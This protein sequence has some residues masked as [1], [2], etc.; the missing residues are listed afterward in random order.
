MYFSEAVNPL[1]RTREIK[2]GATLSVCVKDG[3]GNVTFRHGTEGT[4]G[5][6]SGIFVHDQTLTLYKFLEKDYCEVW[7]KVCMCVSVWV[8]SSNKKLIFT[9]R[10]LNVQNVIFPS[11]VKFDAKF[12]PS[13]LLTFEDLPGSG[14]SSRPDKCVKFWQMWAGQTFNW[15]ADQVNLCTSWQHLVLRYSQRIPQDW[16]SGHS[17]NKK[18]VNFQMKASDY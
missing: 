16:L 1:T 14:D 3:K 18:M 6:V 11:F 15:R 2:V 8:S 9:L 17:E 12:T 5:K 4:N 10:S 7:G 13:T